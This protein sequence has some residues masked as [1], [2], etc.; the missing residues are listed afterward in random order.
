MNRA[1]RSVSIKETVVRSYPHPDRGNGEALQ[2][3]EQRKRTRGDVG[4]MG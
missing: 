1:T 3:Q 2:H 4:D